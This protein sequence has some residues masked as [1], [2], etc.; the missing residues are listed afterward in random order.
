MENIQ[1][2]YHQSERE[3]QKEEQ[4]LRKAIKSPGSFAPI[5]NKYYLS[6]FKFVLQRVENEHIASEIVSDVFSKAI[7]NLKKY[8]FKGTPFSAWLY[9]VAY[10]EIVTTF[11]RKQKKRTVNIPD[12][13]WS[14]LV[15]E[16]NEKKED[17]TPSIMKMKQCLQK[18][19]PSEVELIEMRFFEERAF[20]EIAEILGITTENARVKTHRAL[21]KLQKIFKSV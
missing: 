6:I 12:G 3:I 17:N 7:F 11:R 14:L 2:K 1:N 13:S 4:I 8:K 18:L 5:Y 21:K 20:K 15:S 10:N 19:K 16:E 9:R